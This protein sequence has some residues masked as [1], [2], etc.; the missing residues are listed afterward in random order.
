MKNKLTD[1]NDHLFAQL[2]RLGNEDLSADA[3][4]AE[5]SRAKAVSGVASQIIDN[6]KLALEATRLQV[7]YGGITREPIK[8]PEM[9]EMKKDA[10]RSIS[11]K[12]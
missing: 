1:L 2:E 6:A 11:K 8:L 4:N 10:A 9:L 3:L 7:E 5:I 12:E